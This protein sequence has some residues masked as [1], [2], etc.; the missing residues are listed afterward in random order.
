MLLVLA[1]RELAVT[2]ACSLDKLQQ[3]H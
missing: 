3:K 2:G 1:P